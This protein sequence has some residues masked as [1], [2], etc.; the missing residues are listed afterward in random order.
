MSDPE[1]RQK[2]WEQLQR[3]KKIRR[4][5]RNIQYKKSKFKEKYKREHHIDIKDKF[6]EALDKLKI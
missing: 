5:K 3:E 2:R 1:N 4:R 6:Q